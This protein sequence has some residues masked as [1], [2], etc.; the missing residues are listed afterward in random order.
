MRNGNAS[1]SVPTVDI[2]GNPV[3]PAGATGPLQTVSL[4]GKDPNRLTA[5]STGNVAK[6]LKDY[7]LPNN[8]LSGDGLNTGGFYWQQPGTADNNLY[9]LRLD[10]VLT[11]STRLAFSMQLERGNALN[12]FQ[13]QVYPDQPS[14]AALP[15]TNVYSF[16]ATTTAR[17]DL[18]NE[19][20]VGVNRFGVTYETPFSPGRNE[21]LPHI[22]AQPFY[23]NFLSVTDEY[24]A[25]NAPQGR[26]SP[27]YQVSDKVTWL[28]GRHALKA[29]FEAYFTSSNGF[30]SFRV[31][32]EALTGPGRR[33]DPEHQHDQRH[34][35]QFARWRRTSCSDLSGSLGVV[36]RRHSIRRAA[37]I[38][39]TFRASR[40]SGPGGSALMPG[41]CRTTGNCVPAVT[42]NLGVRYEYYGTP[43]EANGKA[44]IPV[45]G[46]AG[47]FGL[48]GS[49]FADAFQPGHLA[50]SLTQLQLVGP[51]SPNPDGSI[52]K[53]DLNNFAPAVGLS[54]AMNP[55]TV[56][57]AG[58]SIAY[59]RNSLRNADTEVGSN[60]GINS[61]LTFTS[62][63]AMNLANVGV[64]F[65]PT[66]Q[67][68]S[69]VPLDDRTQTLRLYDSGLV[70]PYVQNWNVSLQREIV[71]DSVLTVR[72]VGTKGTRL[73]SGPDL[74]Q[75]EIFSNGFLDAFNVTRAGGNAPLFDRLFAG[76]A[77]AGRGNVDGVTVRG[78]DYARA[79]STFAGYLADGRVGTFIN[80]LNSSRD[81]GQRERRSADAGRTAGELL[82]HQSAVRDGVPGGQQRQLHLPFAAGRVRKALQPRLGLPGQLH[83]E[84]GARRE[85]RHGADI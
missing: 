3:A 31:M 46:S 36:G 55:K 41:I 58:Y 28:K 44:V 75:G 8:F 74:N 17:A 23:F 35:H 14:D 68:M 61:T 71:K 51:R 57:R 29:G 63:S 49:S 79:N 25:N 19:F 2:D 53:K 18:L 78:S 15:R 67:A 10:H 4:F 42:F 6:A 60:P 84:Q 65:A 85:R 40:C 56:L 82:L 77:V 80:N 59:D 48:S 54:W 73:L 70:T 7:P 21:V 32:P 13:G 24:T 43:F 69:T 1:A 5:D 26:R 20:R 62:G 38:R 81:P 12:G 83:L 16:S 47:A 50:G 37:R 45:G 11:E 72:Y 76:L 34:R 66:G 30:N 64:P 9:N 22:G 39:L 27:V 52:Y 33:A